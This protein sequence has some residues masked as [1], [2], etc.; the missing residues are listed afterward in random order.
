[1]YN[2][3]KRTVHLFF[4][5]CLNVEL[6]SLLC[7]FTSILFHINYHSCSSLWKIRVIFLCSSWILSKI[8]YQ[9]M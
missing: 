2:S 9:T 3:N 4:N 8:T 7:S 1:M 6:K 5:L